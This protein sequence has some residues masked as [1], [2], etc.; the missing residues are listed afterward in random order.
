[1]SGR[2]LPTLQAIVVQD[3]GAEPVQIPSGILK[4]QVSYRLLPKNVDASLYA[5][6]WVCEFDSGEASF[7]GYGRTRTQ[8]FSQLRRAM[9]PDA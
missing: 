5:G 2:E 8:A 4:Q 7:T 6:R 3:E 1:M 9:K